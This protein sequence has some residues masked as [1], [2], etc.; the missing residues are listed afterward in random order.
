MNQDYPI[1]PVHVQRDLTESESP[2]KFSLRPGHRYEN[3][4]TDD[5][6][7]VAMVY[8]AVNDERTKILLDSGAS[9]SVT[10]FGPN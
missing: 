3:R 7:D 9:G 4:E 6:H 8:G 1:E 5:S 10:G 2:V